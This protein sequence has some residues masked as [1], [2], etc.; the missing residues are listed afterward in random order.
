MKF[1]QTTT[2][3]AKKQCLQ[4]SVFM[5]CYVNLPL[6]YGILASS[7]SKSSSFHLFQCWFCLLNFAFLFDAQHDMQ[8]SYLSESSNNCPQR[9]KNLGWWNLSSY[10][11]N[12]YLSTPPLQFKGASIFWRGNQGRGRKAVQINSDKGFFSAAFIYD[13][14]LV[15]GDQGKGFIWPTDTSLI[16][17]ESSPLMKWCTCQGRFSTKILLKKLWMLGEPLNDHRHW[18]GVTNWVNKDTSSHV[19]VQ[20][21]TVTG[22][23][24]NV[25]LFVYLF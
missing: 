3:N 1:E 2:F 10:H 17:G 16:A 19:R 25:F 11:T 7:T 23:Y 15:C 24:K 21:H 9:K 14:R 5:F 6:Y 8:S 20:I 18:S 4:R 22:R 12:H 13:R